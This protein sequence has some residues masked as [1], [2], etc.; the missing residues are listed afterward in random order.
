MSASGMIVCTRFVRVTMAP[1]MIVPLVA[2]D[3]RARV[4]RIFSESRSQ[5]EDETT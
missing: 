2:Q 4:H 5:A 1:G 3:S